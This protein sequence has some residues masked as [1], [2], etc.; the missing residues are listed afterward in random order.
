MP[1][2]K[3]VAKKTVAKKAVTPVKKVTKTLVTKVTPV[4][5]KVAPKKK[6]IA[7]KVDP[8]V[9][10]ITKLKDLVVRLAHANLPDMEAKS[11]DEVEDWDYF[12]EQLN[13]RIDASLAY[14]LESAEAE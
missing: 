11:V 14:R 4:V 10:E 12:V 8:A 7:K 5:K 3:S 13:T 1:A 9:K 6:T 2:K